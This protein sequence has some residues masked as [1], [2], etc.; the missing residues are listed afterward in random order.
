MGGLLGK[1]GQDWVIELLFMKLN[2][3]DKASYNQELG[4]VWF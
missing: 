3:L 1:I 2:K 4:Y